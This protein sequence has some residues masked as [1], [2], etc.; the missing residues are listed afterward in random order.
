MS[1]LSAR[2]SSVFPS[3]VANPIPTPIRKGA[4]PGGTCL[5]VGCIP[6]KALLHTSHLCRG[7]ARVCRTRHFRG[8][9]VYRCAEDDRAQERHRRLFTGGIKGLFKKNKVTLLNGHGSFAGGSE[10]ARQVKVG[11]ETV[12]AA[13]PSLPPDRGHD[14]PGVRRSTMRWCATT[15]VR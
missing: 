13:T 6:P 10:G 1:R 5:N 12:E 3:P 7:G 4:A 14:L 15:S 11:E 8:V 9:A 2:H